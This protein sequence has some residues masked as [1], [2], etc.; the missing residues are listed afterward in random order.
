MNILALIVAVV[1]ILS[2]VQGGQR[3]VRDWA[4]S[5][6]A[7]QRKEVRNAWFFKILINKLQEKDFLGFL[8]SEIVPNLCNRG[9]IDAYLNLRAKYERQSEKSCLKDKIAR[10]K[11]TGFF[12]LIDYEFETFVYK[13]WK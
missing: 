11:L 6:H 7:L 9:N 5:L 8:W 4:Q 1:L 3:L 13:I 12:C 2:L 10:L